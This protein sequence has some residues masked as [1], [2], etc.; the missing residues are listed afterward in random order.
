MTIAELRRRAW[1]AA[2]RIELPLAAA[3]VL[4][5]AA[6]VEADPARLAVSCALGLCLLALAWIDARR[7]RLPDRLTLPLL[8]AGLAEA[9]LLEPDAVLD[10]AL[11]A[12]AGYL[13]FRALAEL[14]AW[15]RGRAGLGHGDAKLLGAAGAW[16]GWQALP[17][18]VLVAAVA[19]LAA[20][21][22]RAVRA[23][24]LDAARPLPFG[25]FLALAFWLVWLSG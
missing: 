5:S 21:L 11:G 2:R 16:V 8:L 19:A 18:L 20:I 17:E 15:L 7:M 6:L 12:A 24:H 10:R 3:A 25:P 23:G 14:Y 4:A 9:A 22:L 1:N 13:A